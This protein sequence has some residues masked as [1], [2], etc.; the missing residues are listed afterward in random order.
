MGESMSKLTNNERIDEAVKKYQKELPRLVK[1]LKRILKSAEADEDV[2]AV[3]K[4][5]NFL[6]VCY[7]DLG[8]RSSILPCAMKAVGV[9][10]KSNNHNF[11]SRS[12]NML[13]LAY[14]AQGN[15]QLALS[16]YNKAL[17]TVRNRKHPGLNRDTI[18]NNIAECYYQMGEYRKAIRIY[19]DC[20]QVVRTT[21]PDDHICAVVFGINISDCY[22]SCGDYQKSLNILDVIKPNFEVLDREVLVWGYYGRR[23]C[24][25]YLLGMI[26]EAEMYADLVIEAVTTNYD[27]YEFHRDFEKIAALE[28]KNG[29]FVRAQRFADILTKYADENGNTIDLILSKRVQANIFYAKGDL[30]SA[31][32]LYKELNVL[33]ERR[34]KEENAMQ[35][36]IQKNADSATKEVTKLLKRVRDSEQRA[37]RD[38]LTGL[39]NRSALTN[40]AE[41]FYREARDHGKCLGGVFLDI[42]Y[43]KEYNDTYGHAAGDEAIKFIAKLCM[44][45]ETS[46]V[47]FFRYGGDEYFGFVLGHKDKDLQ[48]LA[49]RISEKVRASGLDHVKNPNGQRIT[50][51]IGIVNIDMKKSDDSVLDIIKYADRALYHAKDRGKDDVFEY[52]EIGDSE[53]EYRRVRSDRKQKR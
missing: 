27:S 26:E 17:A 36:E 32:S 19:E 42:D 15:Y 29:D 20:F 8:D 7:F 40:I 13:G 11:L 30:D 5:N 38:P 44:E 3:G 10:E 9:F 21:R 47:K 31:L 51:S 1:A 46:N 18:L 48:A 28:V 12:Y 53:H 50:V 33:Y 24:V 41:K 4:I 43:F 52:Y 2:F 37:Q 23:C 39:M 16:T 14:L 34:I 35:Y 22:E 49:L 45:E 6:S 25:L